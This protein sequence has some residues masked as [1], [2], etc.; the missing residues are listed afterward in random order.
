MTDSRPKTPKPTREQ[1]LQAALR[2]NLRRRKAQAKERAAPPEPTATG[3]EGAADPEVTN[4][5][6]RSGHESEE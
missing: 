6:P 4:G 2:A 5:S 3:G 1:R